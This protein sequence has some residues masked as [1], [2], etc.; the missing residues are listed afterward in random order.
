MKEKTDK[1]T[2]DELKSM[3]RESAKRNHAETS[4]I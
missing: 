4:S 3:V 2:L 1:I